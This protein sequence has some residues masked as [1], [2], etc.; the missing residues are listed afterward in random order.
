[1]TKALSKAILSLQR[2]FRNKF[3]KNPANRNRLIYTRQRN[4]CL[5][6]LRK[7][8]REYFANL[9]EKDRNDRNTIIKKIIKLSLNKAVQDI[10][11]P[12]R[13]LKELLTILLNIYIQFNEAI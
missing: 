1:M 7:E 8:K 2:W 10:D 12:V 9:Y 11:I 4:F 3:L 5:S 6:F 13:I